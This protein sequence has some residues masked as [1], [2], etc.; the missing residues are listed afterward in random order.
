MGFDL[1]LENLPSF[2]VRLSGQEM[3]VTGWRNSKLAVAFTNRKAKAER[4]A[5][6]DPKHTQTKGIRAS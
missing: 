1:L 4:E 3:Q 5:S 6:C 2:K